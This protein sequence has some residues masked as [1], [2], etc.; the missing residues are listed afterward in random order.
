MFENT[1]RQSTICEILFGE[2]LELL[3][4]SNIDGI[5]ERVKGFYLEYLQEYPSSRRNHFIKWFFQF[6]EQHDY[7]KSVFKAT[8]DAL[9]S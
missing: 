1:E 3:K 2:E 7:L 6:R 4:Q 8:T 9:I 5:L